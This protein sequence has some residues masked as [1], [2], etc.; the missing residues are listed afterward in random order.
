MIVGSFWLPAVPPFAIALM[1]NSGLPLLSG[2]L[3]KGLPKHE[4]FL[5]NEKIKHFFSTWESF[6]W[7]GKGKIITG[8]S[9]GTLAG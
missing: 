2:L 4:T 5:R 8:R 9:M 1:K 6:L 3:N 7:N